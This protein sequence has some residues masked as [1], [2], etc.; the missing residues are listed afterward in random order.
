MG[1]KDIQARAKSSTTDIVRKSKKLGSKIAE[2]HLADRMRKT[3]DGL[4][5]RG[6]KASD[7]AKEWL[8]EK[9]LGITERTNVKNWYQ[10]AANAC[11]ACSDAI[12][13]EQPGT[14]SKISR[15][16][17]AKL[18]AASASAG[19][20]S[21]AALV[22]TA[23]TGTAIGSLSGAAFT[24][25]TLAWV[26]GSVAMGSVIIGIASVAGG[27][28]AAFGAAWASKKA[29]WGGRRQRSELEDKERRVLDACLALATAFREKSK[30]GDSID[31]VSAKHLAAEALAPLCEELLELNNKV[32]KWPYM[33]RQR[34]RRATEGLCRVSNYLSDWSKKRPN[35]T[36]GVVSAVIIRLMANDLESFNE[37]EQL[38]LEAIRRSNNTLSNASNEELA[39]YVQS[40]KSSQ[41]QGLQNNIKGIYHELRF[42]ERENSD[43]DHYVAELFGATNHPGADVRII[44][45]E[46]G[47]IREVQLKATNY[48]SSIRKHNEKYESTDVFATSE[49]ADAA[50]GIESTGLSNEELTDE[51][52]GVISKLGKDDDGGVLTSMSVAGI[53]ALARNVR[54]SLKGESLSKEEKSRLV[55]DGAVSASVAGLMALILG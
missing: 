37:N 12:L 4:G 19:I 5:S 35:V 18:G 17:A 53:I 34:L 40:I 36:T 16:V 20:F 24:S 44:N 43:G 14:S 23:S 50:Q 25:A 52:K 41:L 1:L 54:V 10:N 46:T 26:G 48:L 33:A 31:P 32:N 38:V 7:D 45:L 27:I 21:I 29:L 28:G 42:V 3:K 22:G 15:G 30:L 49:V 8:Q 51:A 2:G 9:Y 6:K 13:R 47:E 11:E 39:I 55:E